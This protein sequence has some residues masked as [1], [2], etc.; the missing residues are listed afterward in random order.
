MERINYEDGILRVDIDGNAG[1]VYRLYQA[2]FDRTPDQD[3]LEYWID[4]R[5]G[6]STMTQIANN[7]IL[8][9]EFQDLYGDPDTVSNEAFL[10][11]VYQNVLNRTPDQAGY[12]YW[13]AELERGFG[14]DALLASF[15]ESDENIANVAPA[16][17]NGIFFEFS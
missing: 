14:R 11:L 15:S 9:D 12:A 7:F 3:G 4:E 8:S 5:D 17:S 10:T 6:G 16:I 1:E 13:I 2:A